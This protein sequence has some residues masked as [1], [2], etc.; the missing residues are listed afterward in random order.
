MA[1]AGLDLERLAAPAGTADELLLEATGGD[2]LARLALGAGAPEAAEAARLWQAMT[3][4]PGIARLLDELA[5]LAEEDVM[6]LLARLGG[7]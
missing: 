2:A 5:D 4:A 7:G 3:A 1:G 6:R